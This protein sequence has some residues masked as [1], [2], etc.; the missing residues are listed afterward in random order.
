VLTHMSV[1]RLCHFLGLSLRLQTTR[2]ESLLQPMRA[3]HR[4]VYYRMKSESI[5][6]NLTHT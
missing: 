5:R 6:C 1:L 3:R 2:M 4:L